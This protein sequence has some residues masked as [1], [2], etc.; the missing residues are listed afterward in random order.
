MTTLMH[1]LQ[2]VPAQAEF[3]ALVR[4]LGWTL[5]HFCWQGA[6]VAALL[7]CV[8]ALLPVR[9]PRARYAAA[10]LALALMVALPL[11]TFAR[12]AEKEVRASRE[13]RALPM[14]MT[15][16]IVVDAGAGDKREPMRLRIAR[17]LDDSAPWVPA[18]WLAGVVVFLARLNLGLIVARR[19]RSAVT[20]PAQ[21]GLRESFAR[22]RERL[23]VTRAV[24]LVQSAMVEAPTVIGWLRPV[25]L[26]P[27]GCLTGL[28]IAQIEAVLAHELAHIRRH[29]YLVSVL[30][31]VVEALLFYHPAVWWVSRQMRRERES[32]CDDVAVKVS[33]DRISYA[34]ALSWLEEH[35]AATPDMVLGA[36]GGVLTMRIRRL[37]GLKENAAVSRGVAMALLAGVVAGAVWYAG[38][39][40]RA[41]SS[42]A[43]PKAAAQET[44]PASASSATAAPS[45]AAAA[46]QH[47][48][49]QG[50][51]PK[52][53]ESDPEFRDLTP[54]EQQRLRER[55]ARLD[56]MSAVMQVR[57]DEAARRAQEVTAKLNSP[58]FKKQM[59]DA[60][61]AAAR[62]NSPEF[63]KQYEDAQRA[64]QD[65]SNVKVQAMISRLYSEEYQKAIAQAEAAA[66][67]VNA[68]ELQEKLYASM[69]A[70]EEANLFLFKGRQ[71]QPLAQ[72]S[73]AAAPA[74][75]G[76]AQGGGA[77]SGTIVDPTGALV[78]RAQVAATN[79][80]TGVQVKVLTD[81]TGKYSLSPL[82]AGPYNV[83][84]IARGFQ[85][86]L[87]ENVQVGAGKQAELD[88]K[89]TAGGG[90]T[91]LTV[92]GAPVAAPPPPPAFTARVESPTAPA[93]VSSGTLAGNLISRPDPV[94]P[95]EAKAAHVEGAVVLRA[96]ISKEGSIKKLTY[97]SG[98]PPLVVSAIDAVEKWK[99]K[100]YLLN[101]E[102]T[103][104]E[105]TITVN[106]TFEGSTQNQAQ[107]GDRRNMS[108]AST[109]IRTAGPPDAE[110]QQA[111]LEYRELA[112]RASAE[113]SAYEA[114]ALAKQTPAIDS[115][116]QTVRHVGGGVSAP[117]LTQSIPPEYTPEA[118]KAK[119]EG[120]VLLNL[121]VDPNGM[122]EDVHV[123][124]GVGNGL[125]EKAVEA[126]KQYKFKPAMEDGKPVAAA[127]S[128]EVNFK[129]F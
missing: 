68:P 117:V 93:R 106:Y 16:A 124:R 19:M 50:E 52:A 85:R 112:K 5:L 119:T 99:Y 43:Q 2:G 47:E 116:G 18:V 61:A 103:E 90:N 51:R 56:A 27:V 78:P 59:A 114:L 75:A 49:A 41:Q 46:P 86:L 80:D 129:L 121:I 94:Y 55:V 17:A 118:R 66:A 54:E 111:L 110:V 37:L 63:R 10:S 38:A 82:P 127:V 92:T 62:V 34:R 25:V 39:V 20:E 89:L 22:L 1:M 57:A 44:A 8:L 9:M 109:P 26:I 123:L 126:V 107:P 104:V 79:T 42:Q 120:V 105:T 91:T 45:A 88:E 125:D 53:L 69:K 73:A 14:V 122:P 24:R 33:G 83:E 23:G 95:D 60:M 15:P 113:S 108:E 6:A 11:A 115:A 13:L 35:R 67:R 84:V 97:I 31:S 102:P 58:E 77:I 29:D 32:C 28:S 100:P 81:N 48:A 98:P 40:A 74:R 128:V 65:T 70:A 101:G 21:D 4:A 12:L 72:S 71:S 87:Q 3:P 96:V 30:Q 7:W 36:N 76:A 64:A